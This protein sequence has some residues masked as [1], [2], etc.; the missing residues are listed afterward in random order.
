MS[1]IKRNQQYPSI[2]SLVN[3]FLSADRFFEKNPFF[4][5]SWQVPAVN[6]K[7]SDTAFE[8]EVAAPGLEKKD[9]KIELDN[10]LLRISAE[11][12]EEKNET[13][14]DY[15]RREFSYSSFVRSFELPMYVNAE[16]IDA[17]YKEGILKL[18]LPKKEEA[19]AKKRKEI[20]IA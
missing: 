16:G 17:Q 20:P 9:F 14:A 7:E 12:N 1:V 11:R 2:R 8:L 13:K 15:T 5:E 10:N 3:D 6:I 18:V 19:T 4:N